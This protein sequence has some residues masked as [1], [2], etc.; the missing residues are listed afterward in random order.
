[1]NYEAAIAYAHQRM[2]EIGKQPNE[3]HFEPVRVYPTNVENAL[4]Y[5]AINAYNE[6]YI[7]IQP[8]N[9]YCLFIVAD[10][11]VFNSDNPLDSGAPEFT[12]R[13]HFYR[14]NNLWS[15]NIIGTDAFGSQTNKIVPVEFLRVVIY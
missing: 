1:M 7:L 9:Y 13:I 11:S 6:V 8:E 12:G 2:R 5:F 15:F 3:Y 4:G 10:N 14:I